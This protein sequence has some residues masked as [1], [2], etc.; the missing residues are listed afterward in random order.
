[1]A[2]DLDLAHMTVATLFVFFAYAL[3]TLLVKF[4]GTLHWYI[5]GPSNFV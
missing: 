2:Y 3:W 1:M 5:I 4:E